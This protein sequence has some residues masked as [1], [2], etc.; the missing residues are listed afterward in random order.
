[1]YKKC[2]RVPRG[3][4]TSKPM[5]VSVGRTIPLEIIEKMGESE[6]ITERLIEDLVKSSFDD[7]GFRRR[8]LRRRPFGFGP[9]IRGTSFV[10]DGTCRV[11]ES[12]C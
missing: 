6:G 5:G 8:V 2:P 1:M 4:P 12:C 3:L 7:R 10:R 11:D 9:T